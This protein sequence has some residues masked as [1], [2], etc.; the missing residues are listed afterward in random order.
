M[1]QDPAVSDPIYDLP[2]PI[3]PASMRDWIAACEAERQAGEGLLML[4]LDEA[5]ALSGYSK[6]TV[7]PDRSS[8]E[9]AGAV[10]A[11]RQN[12]G[13]GGA[14]AG[15]TFNWVFETLG[16]RLMGLTAA[17]DNIRSA[18][19]IEAVGFTRMGERDSAMADGA[20]RKSL[21][22]EMTRDAW[23]TR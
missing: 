1:L 10:R 17:T 15:E 8:A 2:R 21:Y 3:T 20:V 18:R 12:S 7:W 5:G 22:W 6:I 9:V 23:R 4:T 14:G 19:L 13:R 16:V 11:D